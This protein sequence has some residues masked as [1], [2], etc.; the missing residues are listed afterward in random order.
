M[1]GVM[2][3]M[4]H[5]YDKSPSLERVRCMIASPPGGLTKSVCKP[6]QPP[7]AAPAADFT[8]PG[9]TMPTGTYKGSKTT[10][11]KTPLEA[12]DYVKQVSQAR[13]V[14]ACLW[15]VHERI[16]QPQQALSWRAGHGNDM[17]QG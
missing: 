3:C 17:V 7:A 13:M 10:E 12:N 2:T 8:A 16:M 4:S 5:M 9:S 11:K 15:H 6:L 1:T 14:P